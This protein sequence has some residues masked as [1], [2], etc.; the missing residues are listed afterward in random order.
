MG[1][2]LIFLLR[3]PR[4]G[5]LAGGRGGRVGANAFTNRSSPVML[6]G[7]L[8]CGPGPGHFFQGGELTGM[9]R[10]T[11]KH[12]VWMAILGLGLA[13]WLSACAEVQVAP[14][15]TWPSLV[16]AADGV[17]YYVSGLR[18]PGTRQEIRTRRGDANLWIPLYRIDTIR[19]TAPVVDDYRQADI[20]LASGE[21]LQMEV[22]VNQLL[23]GYTEGGYWNMSMGKLHRLEMGMR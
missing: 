21:I 11:S 3:A 23:E 6:R 5:R 20:V 19:F 14:P 22:D 9:P 15:P 7:E 12:R 1:N 17:H 16:T 10:R 2:C 13:G 4:L 8:R 18:V